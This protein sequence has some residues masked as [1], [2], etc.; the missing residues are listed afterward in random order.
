MLFTKQIKNKSNEKEKSI[1]FI[2]GLTIISNIFRYIFIKTKNLNMSIYYGNKAIM[3]YI[4]YIYIIGNLDSESAT[5]NESKKFKPNVVQFIYKKTIY[6]IKQT[7]QK[8]N[9]NNSISFQNIDKIISIYNNLISYLAYNDQL[10]KSPQIITQFSLNMNSYIYN[11]ELIYNLVE[12]I[13]NKF[14]KEIKVDTFF[15]VLN[16]SIKNNT[17]SES[18]LKISYLNNCD[19]DTIMSVISF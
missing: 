3:L 18:T 1:F 4:D 5:G 7:K 9:I 12:N 6:N 11:V 16:E 13:L 17:K 15:D 10:K 8:I 14:G 19:K 2:K